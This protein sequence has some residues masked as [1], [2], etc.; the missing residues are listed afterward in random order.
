MIHLLTAY[1]IEPESTGLYWVGNF[2]PDHAGTRELKDKIHLRGTADRDAALRG[3]RR[4]IDINDPFERGWLVHMFADYCWDINEFSAY[5]DWYLSAHGD[6]NWF[7]SYREETGI[8]SYYLY[9][10]LPW[11]RLVWEQIKQT[12]LKPVNTK[13][14]ITLAD[15][16]RYRDNVVRRHEESDPGCESLIYTMDTL[17]GFARATAEKYR[18]WLKS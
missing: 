18:I 5:R 4:Q 3:L 11:P 16:E 14:P 9:H 12:D 10:N 7:S 13:L 17:T 8:A 6:G 1:E 2:A 15:N